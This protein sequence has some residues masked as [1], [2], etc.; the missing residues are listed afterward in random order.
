MTRLAALASIY[1]ATGSTE[2]LHA[3]DWVLHSEVPFISMQGYESTEQFW[4]VPLPPRKP[5]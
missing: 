2:V 3:H 1:N 4:I 5:H